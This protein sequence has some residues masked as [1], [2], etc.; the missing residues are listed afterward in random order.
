MYVT[1]IPRI[2]IYIY[3]YIEDALRASTAA[4]FPSGPFRRTLQEK[5][6]EENF[7][8]FENRKQKLY[9]N[10][11]KNIIK[12]DLK[13]TPKLEKIEVR[14]GLGALGGHLRTKNREITV[15]ADFGRF[16]PASGRP[17]WS[18]VG[19][20]WRQVGPKMAPRWPKNRQKSM[21][22]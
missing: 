4:P 13:M 7:R 1:C 5:N 15:L 12:N 11:L 20:S 22:N 18:Q 8:K 3:I 16:W 17:K 2:Y 10:P 9:T 6:I 14:R 21:K 19:Q